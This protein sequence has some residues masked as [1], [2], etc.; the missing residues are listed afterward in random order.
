[1]NNHQKTILLVEDEALIALDLKRTLERMGHEVIGPFSSSGDAVSA[2]NRK[3]VDLALLDVN[4]GDG[5]TSVPVAQTLAER[6]VPFA[7]LTG[8]VA[9][10]SVLDS[11]FDGVE[12]IA[13]PCTPNDLSA[14]V[15]RLTA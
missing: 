14:T 4:L 5:D 8:Y 3:I 12:R 2:A 11:H 9:G 10:N 15:E 13:K 1:M 7:F 6:S